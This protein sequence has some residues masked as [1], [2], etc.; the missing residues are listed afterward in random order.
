[1]SIPVLI[2]A[3]RD[4]QALQR[5]IETIQTQTVVCEPMVHDNSLNNIGLTKGANKLLSVAL[6]Q[7]ATYAVWVNQDVVLMPDTV[8]QAV[9]F[10]DAHPRCAIAG[11]KQLDL[12]DPDRIT[13]GGTGDAYPAGVHLTGLV[14]KGDH[15]ESK[16]FGWVNGA[17]VIFR[18]DAIA[19][20]GPLDDRYFLY[21]N[22]SD[23]CLTAGLAGWEVWY[24]A[25]AVVHHE[26]HGC[27]RNPSPEQMKILQADTA[28][29]EQKWSGYF[30][31]E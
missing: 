18:M 5:C 19:E 7:N 23:W 24:C 20:I 16:R 27:A 28:A 3:Y 26:S 12:S 25:D 8:E 2:V 21:F 31:R 1:M 6:M 13:H 15:A 22:D 9:A 11:M 14:S 17:A 29:F 30:D 4:W 10:M